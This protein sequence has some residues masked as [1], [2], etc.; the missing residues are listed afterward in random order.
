MHDM[1]KS[2]AGRT[3]PIIVLCMILCAPPLARGEE[4]NPPGAAKPT[5]SGVE[6]VSKDYPALYQEGIREYGSGDFPAALKSF[7]QAV[8][9]NPQGADALYS[10][11][12]MYQKGEGVAASEVEAVSYFRA[13]WRNGHKEAYGQLSHLY[14]GALAKSKGASGD[15]SVVP[16]APAEPGKT[17][18]RGALADQVVIELPLEAVAAMKDVHFRSSHDDKYRI[19]L[20]CPDNCT[21]LAEK[22]GKIA[23][24]LGGT[25][26]ADQGASRSLE[27]EH[28]EFISFQ[29]A[30]QSRSVQGISSEVAG[31]LDLMVTC[32]GWC[33][34][35]KVVA[36][37]IAEIFGQLDQE[38]S[39]SWVKGAVVANGPQ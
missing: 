3:W 18:P 27:P 5:A 36:H 29:G 38:N 13:A 35:I 23:A 12:V 16:P 24:R 22:A 25:V 31:A 26:A 21:D 7:L 8:K 11:G 6:A 14:E 2:L 37:S 33:G 19:V 10:L 32:T 1:H 34:I 28:Y 15:P 20:S 39:A 30:P 17:G 9:L 4:A